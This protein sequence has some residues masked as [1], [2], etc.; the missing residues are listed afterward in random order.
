MLKVVVDYYT[1]TNPIGTGSI[2]SRSSTIVNKSAHFQN[3]LKLTQKAG[4]VGLKVVPHRKRNYLTG[5]SGFGKI[6]AMRGIGG[7][8]TVPASTL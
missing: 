5:E 2:S 6:W 7:T 3:N 1:T 4:T 8:A